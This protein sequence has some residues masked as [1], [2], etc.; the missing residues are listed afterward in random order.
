MA[1]Y[2][3]FWRRNPIVNFALIIVLVVGTLLTVAGCGNSQN[4]VA[5]PA[6]NSAK[7][8]KV[9]YSGSACE[10]FIYAAYEKGFFQ[11]E[12]LDVE[13]VKVDFE[14]LK[15]ALATGKIQ[16][17]D[18]M[19]MKWMKPFEQ[20]VD[21]T[22]TAGIHT[23][24]FQLLV[25]KNSD[26]K[27]PANLK[28]KTIGVT[29]MGD[30]PM[31]FSMRVLFHEGLDPQKDVQWR[32]YPPTE[33]DGALARGEVDAIAL[34]DPLAQMIVES[35]KAV[36]LVNTASDA[37]FKDEYCCMVTIAG[38]FIKEDPAGAAAVTRA[39]MKGAKWVSENPDEAAKLA[40][41]KKYVPGSP[42]LISRLLKSYNYI[43]SV[44]GGRQA[45]KLAI[46]EMKAVGVLDPNTNEAELEQKAFTTLDGVN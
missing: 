27:S 43:P 46:K 37:P 2:K 26:I 24:C 25:P 9:G 13:L 29:G 5:T 14:T 10:A 17:S 4:G 15:E 31:I 28:G 22:F 45:L 44:E 1:F 41:D 6:P 18:G 40:V 8:I 3:N 36:K 38:S 33:L 12:G 19:P 35:G 23:G 30:A 20:G 16:A 42:E 11:A 32:S 39:L 34:N 7:K 21:A